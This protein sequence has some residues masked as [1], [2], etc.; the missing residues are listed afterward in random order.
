MSTTYLKSESQSIWARNARSKIADD[1]TIP[2]DARRGSQ[3]IVIHPGSRSLIIGRASDVTPIIIPN[4]V[5]RKCKPPV[6]APTRVEGISRPR[7]STNSEDEL[8]EKDPF[9]D[10]ISAITVSLRDRMRF[11]KL[12]VTP[13]A[14]AIASTFNEQFKPEII[15]E[16][17]DPFR[18]E[19]TENMSSEEAYFGEKAPFVLQTR[20]KRGTLFAGQ[21]TLRTSI[22]ETIRPYK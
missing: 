2:Q 1:S 21:Y 4:V 7:G 11:Y 3:V 6:P 9:E 19:W 17:N 5:A 18:V 8:S 14:T 12:R 13:N 15:A 22:Q 10:K 16:Y 20:K